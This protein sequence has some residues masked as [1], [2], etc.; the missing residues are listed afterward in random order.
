MREINSVIL[1]T[2]ASIA[3]IRKRFI[4][5][6]NTMPYDVD[7]W[8]EIVW[9]F[10]VERENKEWCGVINLN[11]FCLCGDDIADKLFGLTKH[12]CEEPYFAKRGVPEDCCEYVAEDV[13]RNDEFIK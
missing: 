13:K 6:R 10:S 3:D 2:I 4:F 1:I 9:D 5:D 8:I 7:G 12:P 11:R